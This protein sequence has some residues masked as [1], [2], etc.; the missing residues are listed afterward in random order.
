MSYLQ[1]KAVVIV[2]RKIDETFIIK[3]FSV[4]KYKNVKMYASHG[5]TFGQIL[6][7]CVSQSLCGTSGGI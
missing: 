4:I 2:I 7:K 5:E 6:Q 1:Y 3:Y